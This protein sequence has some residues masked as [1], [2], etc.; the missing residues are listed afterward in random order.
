MRLDT[1]VKMSPKVRGN[2]NHICKRRV[3]WEAL[4]GVCACVL[5][6][7][8]S[9]SFVCVFRV[10]SSRCASASIWLAVLSWGA[11]VATSRV[12]VGAH[13][14]SDVGAGSSLTWLV[15]LLLWGRFDGG[16]EANV[17]TH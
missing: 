15:A 14:L 1:F 7:T 16:A 11:T 8:Q 12:A 5:M 9:V 6:L 10:D 13:W 4:V 2:L 17:E 3:A